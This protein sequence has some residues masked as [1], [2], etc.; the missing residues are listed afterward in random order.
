[1]AALGTLLRELVDPAEVDRTRRLPAGLVERLRRDG[2]AGLT[3]DPA[4]GG[5]GLSPLSAVRVLEAAASWS[6]AVAWMLAISA[7][8][9]AG[10]YLPMIPDGPLRDLVIAAA[11][12]GNLGGSA[13]TEAS[14]AANQ[15]RATTA[16]P[17]DGGRAYELT[18]EKVFIGNSPVAGLVDVAATV[19]TDA[20]EQL[21]VFFVPTD[22]PGVRAVLRQDFLGLA[23]APIGVLR[24]TAARV[25]AE[26]LLPATAGRWR[27]EKELVRLVLLARTLAIA[28]PALAI[29]KLCLA[30]SRDFVGRRK[31]DGRPLGSYDEIQRRV[32]T[33]AADVFAAGAAVEWALLGADPTDREAELT[34]LKNLTSV[35]CWRV[36]DRTVGLLGGEGVETAASKAA[37]GAVPLPVE[38]FARDAR[39]LRV[40]GGVDFLL[41]YWTALGVLETVRAD[42]AAGPPVDPPALPGRCGRHAAYL[43]GEAARLAA[44]ARAL[45]DRYGPA[46]LAEREH[47]L[48]VLG[49]ISTG[50]L[51]MAVALAKAAA[52]GDPL[53]AELADVACVDERHR[54]AGL[55]AELAGDTEPDYAGLSARLLGTDLEPLLAD[56]L[57]ALP[58]AG[59][60]SGA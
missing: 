35:A 17:V 57:T 41:D 60:V 26:N 54:L 31:M 15:R 33:S 45:L 46:E 43:A 38:R 24:L 7:G 5:L 6:P 42:P 49:G 20:G 9:G 58:P 12:A 47:P 3:L 44:A 52:L 16:V 59:A 39:V 36:V 4:L 50:L 11:K 19:H 51:A 10:N 21:R 8:F 53:S 28:P 25:P 14:G 37:R 32:A 2:Y 27:E 29:A 40:S 22:T 56:V 55:W 34:A 23:G 18:G 1:M 48:V 13:D 30:W